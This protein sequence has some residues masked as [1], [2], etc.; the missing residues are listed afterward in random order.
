L[1]QIN[2]IARVT[3]VFSMRRSKP[4]AWYAGTTAR[5]RQTANAAAAKL[6]AVAA[7]A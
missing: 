3:A 2:R 4:G 5:T 7:T 6:R 1:S